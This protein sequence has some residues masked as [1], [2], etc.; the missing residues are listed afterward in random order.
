MMYAYAVGIC[1]T[2]GV[3]MSTNT[4]TTKHVLGA[5]FFSAIWPIVW[6]VSIG[7][8]VGRWGAS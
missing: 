3:I 7:V 6:L 4:W 5:L 2:F 8:A 1:L